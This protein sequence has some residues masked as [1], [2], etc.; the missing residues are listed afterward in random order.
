L[1]FPSPSLHGLPPSMSDIELN[2]GL[3]FLRSFYRT[4]CSFGQSIKTCLVVSFPPHSY[5][6]SSLFFS[7]F[8]C[9]ASQGWQVLSCARK[10]ESLLGNLPYKCLT[11]LPGSAE[12]S[13]RRGSPLSEEDHSH[14][15]Y[16]YASA[17][18]RQRDAGL[19]KLCVAGSLITALARWLAI[20]FLWMLIVTGTETR[21]F[22]RN[23][24]N[25][26]GP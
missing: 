5:L 20:S 13:R 18:L 24:P 25:V 4:V 11:Y 9:V 6:W 15:Y 3:I 23:S 16:S 7:L 21:S 17:L 14:V 2:L 19:G 1:S 26:R 10:Y 8:L 22:S 12:S